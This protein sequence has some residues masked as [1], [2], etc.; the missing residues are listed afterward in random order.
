MYDTIVTTDYKLERIGNRNLD[1]M[2]C[3]YI[4]AFESQ[5]LIDEIF[6]RNP[7]LKN[8]TIADTQKYL[9]YFQNKLK[10]EIIRCSKKYEETNRNS[11]KIK[12]ENIYEEYRHVGGMMTLEE[13]I[14]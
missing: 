8:I 4:C 12:I 2:G 6:A 1:E 5:K 14:K 10:K 3:D 13:I 11:W 7:Y 9:E